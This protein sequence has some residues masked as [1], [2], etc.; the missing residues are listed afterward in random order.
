MRMRQH[1]A[2]KITRAFICMMP[3]FAIVAMAVIFVGEAGAETYTWSGGGAPDG[4]WST[5]S[6]WSSGTPVSAS[7]SDVV[8]GT[9]TGASAENNIANPF[10]LRNLTFGAGAG[11]FTL[12][13]WPLTIAGAVTNNAS[14]PQTINNAITLGANSIWNTAT[15]NVSVVGGISGGSFTLVKSGTG[16]LTISGDNSFI[17]PGYAGIAGGV[18]MVS[19]GSFTNLATGTGDAGLRMPFGAV[20]TTLI[21]TNGAKYF[22]PVQTSD[23]YARFSR[24]DSTLVVAGVGSIWNNGSDVIVLDYANG[25]LLVTDGGGVTNTARVFIGFGSNTTSN[26]LQITKGGKINTAANGANYLGYSTGSSW[27]AVYLGGTNG[28][29]GAKSIWNMG[30]GSSSLTV[31]AST[32]GANYNSVTVDAGGVLTNGLLVIG[33][34]S[35]AI[36]NSLVITNGGQVYGMA[37]ASYVGSGGAYS[38]GW[39]GGANLVTGEK[40]IWDIGSSLIVGGSG[41]SNLLTV[42]QNGLVTNIVGNGFKLGDSAGSSYNTVVITNGGQVFSLGSSMIVG[43]GTTSSWNRVIVHNGLLMTG[44]GTGPAIG[45]NSVGNSVTVK[46]DGIWDVGLKGL[47][48]GASYSGSG[49]GTSNSVVVTTGG[50]VTNVCGGERLGIGDGVGAN[51]NSIIVTNGGKLFMAGGNVLI[52]AYRNSSG[53]LSAGG[54]GNWLLMEGGLLDGSVNSYIGNASTANL[55]EL[56]GAAQWNLNNK[57]LTIGLSSGTT[58]ELR[59]GSGA[60]VTGVNTLTIGADA[61][62]VGNQLT[63]AGGNVSVTTFALGA[64]NTLAPVVGLSGITALAVSGSATLAN[65]TWVKPMADSTSAFGKFAILTAGTLTNGGIVL[66]PSVDTTKWSLSVEGNTL[67]LS[68]RETLTLIQIR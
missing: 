29:T 52:G 45:L 40:S 53:G 27:N 15:G 54:N 17:L 49:S 22:S 5:S 58:N 50:V 39:V 10:Q 25:R 43:N 16:T 8:F 14:S 47:Y 38:T 41:N 57:T 65:G 42:A 44:G 32:P 13:G 30:G 56:R 51:F 7:D 59:V 4:G 33:S 66:D 64:G 12:S 1:R 23:K 34:N 2:V 37:N 61:G 6:N 19:G 60:T 62:S 46:A 21:V 20:G 63:L 11:A 35:G 28:V 3:M 48:V 26:R 24:A 68:H 55:A 31:G 36:G 18:L 9:V 67:Y